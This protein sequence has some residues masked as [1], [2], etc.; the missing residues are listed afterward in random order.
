MEE[1]AYAKLNLALHVRARRADGF[2]DIET[3]FAFAE[4]GD[5]LSVSPAS[6]LTLDLTGPFARALEGAD[7]LVL[8][9]A[10]A[11]RER[12]QVREGATLRLDKRLPVASGLGG[13]S[14]DAAATLRLLDRFWRLDAPR[15]A[16]EEIAAAL[17]SDVPACLVSA[18]VRGEGRGER[19][20]LLSP[21]PWTGMPVLLVNPGVGVSTAQVFARWDGIDRGPLADPLAGRNDLEAAARAIAPRIGDV[22][23]ALSG[24]RGTRLVRMSGS[25]ASCFAL[26]ESDSARDAADTQIAAAQPGWWRLAT[27][28]R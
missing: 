19:L 15:Q 14:A 21:D 25:G 10:E 2:H 26:F 24:C 27:R 4:D 7:N 8:A 28:L 1:T 23:A 9:A 22:L 11:L 13:G 6:D 16:L 5:R 3:I 12:C 18:T 20:T 17:G